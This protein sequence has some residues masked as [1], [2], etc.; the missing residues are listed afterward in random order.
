MVRFIRVDLMLLLL[1][2][3]LY[4]CTRTGVEAVKLLSHIGTAITVIIQWSYKP[5]GQ[6]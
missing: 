5:I 3:L 6:I 2:H 1:L 4:V